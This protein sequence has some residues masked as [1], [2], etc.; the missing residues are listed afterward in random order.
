VK[1][2]IRDEVVPAPPKETRLGNCFLGQI[3]A[4]LWQ[5]DNG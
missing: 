4:N 3:W 5:L 2:W 1:L